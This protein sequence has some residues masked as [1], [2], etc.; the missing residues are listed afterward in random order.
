MGNRGPY[1][2]PCRINIDG[3]DYGTV[4][5]NAAA[6]DIPILLYQKRD[7]SPGE[8]TITVTVEA[9]SYPNVCEVDRFM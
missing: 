2:G 5:S 1:H 3:K 4:T 6:D 7:L 9:A 8:H